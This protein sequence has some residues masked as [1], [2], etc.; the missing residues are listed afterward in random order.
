MNIVQNSILNNAVNEFLIKFTGYDKCS[1]NMWFKGEVGGVV[2]RGRASN[3]N[4]R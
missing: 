4:L 1:P 2:I 3:K